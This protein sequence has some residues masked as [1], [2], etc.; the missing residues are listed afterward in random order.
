M[1]APAF[2]F[3]NADTSRGLV[4]SSEASA[5]FYHPLLPVTLL[6]ASGFLLQ[7]NGWNLN[8][9]MADTI[10][11]DGT[12][13]TSVQLL[14]MRAPREPITPMVSWVGPPGRVFRLGAKWRYRWRDSRTGVASGLS[15][16][17]DF[18]R[19]MGV[20]T[21]AGSSTYLG[22]T[23]WF[24]LPTSGKPPAA[25]T[26]DLFAN[27]AQEDDVWYLA[28]S[29]AIGTASYVLLTDNNT[30]EELFGRLFVVTGSAT[31]TPAGPTWSEGVMPPYVKAWLAPTN[32][33]FYF[34]R[35]RWESPGASDA[36]VA[37]VQ[38]SDLATI[39][40]G[41]TLVDP[42]RVLQR[43]RFFSGFNPVVGISDP[44]VYR[45]IKVESATTFRV[46]PEIA[47]SAE[48]AS[49]AS[50]N[51]YFTIEDDIPL[52][53]TQMSEPNK[54]WLIDPLKT[55]AAGDDADDGVLHW[56]TTPGSG[57]LNSATGT[58]RVFMQT[59]RRIYST[60]G[61][62]VSGGAVSDNPA[63]STLFSVA[64]GEGTVGPWSGCE[65]PA[66]WAYW[67]AERGARIFDGV[68][69]RPLERVPDLYGEALAKDQIAT[70]EPSMM[71]EIR[72]VYD[73]ANRVVLFSYVPTGGS[74][75]TRVM[76]FSMPERNWRGPNRDVVMASGKMR[77]TSSS[78][79]LV[80]GDNDGGLL[81]REAQALDVT[82]TVA[83]FA[84]T[85]TITSIESARIFSDSSGPF[86]DGTNTIFAELR[87][88]PIWFTDG[89]DWFFSRIVG[90][91]SATQ[92]ELEGP[93]VKEDGTAAAL[94]VGWTFGIG[95]IRWSLTTAYI[96]AEGDPAKPVEAFYLDLRLRRGATSETFEA[97][98]S[99]DG[100][101]TFYGVADMAPPTRDVNGKIH[102]RMRFKQRGGVVQLRLRGISRA[103]EPQITRPVLV[104]EEF[105]E[106]LKA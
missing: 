37:V 76:A 22:Q 93:P 42:G 78:D 23:A 25:D 86:T 7:L 52:N 4:A 85:G 75:P 14:Q 1:T 63:Q 99:R 103:G 31:A 53:W 90:V 62:V 15:P 104:G 43:V 105:D 71:E 2:K 98:A 44:T 51:W 92:V 19:N 73:E 80:I 100:G 61:S 24:N 41:T 29:Q 65:T 17:P 40:Q 97:G 87:G 106:E 84:G 55:L 11:P 48:L 67:H 34:C 13:A 83:G 10:G 81:V 49:G 5:E 69:S 82:P 66:G 88:S 101:T 95:S 8:R 91:L 79:V 54:P 16:L 28:D 35:K 39:N 45:L 60:S 50:A 9:C 21:P 94:T 68:A 18:E 74:T 64:V 30:D 77:S 59:M 58:G 3:R 56:F 47:V 12:A 70:F 32:R 38:G 57:D 102:A 72:A 20:V 89:T 27:T 46:W 36:R 6:A 33:V 26:I 96:D